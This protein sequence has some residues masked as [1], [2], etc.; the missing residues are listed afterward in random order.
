M[1]HDKPAMKKKLLDALVKFTFSR[2]D[3]HV[4]ALCSPNLIAFFLN[5]IICNKSKILVVSMNV[6]CDDLRQMNHFT[7]Q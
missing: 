2:Y 4:N 6:Y 5:Y 7:S 1:Y 3:G